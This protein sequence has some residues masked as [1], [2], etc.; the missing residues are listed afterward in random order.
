MSKET[1]HLAL[2]CDR[3]VADG[4]VAVIGSSRHSLR[5]D[6]KLSVHVI[7]FGLGDDIRDRVSHMISTR[8]RDTAIE[9]IAVSTDRLK[10]FPK[11]ASLSHVTLV[12]YARLL[13][14]ELLPGVDR[15]IYL[16]CD[17]LV[18]GDLAEIAH[19]RLGDAALAAAIDTVIPCVGHERESLIKDLA[20]LRPDLPY[21]NAGVLVLDLAKLRALDATRLYAEALKKVEARY[22]D[23]SVLN[24]VFHGHWKQLPARWNRQILLGGAFTVF[25]DRSHGIWHFSSKLKPWHFRRRGVRGLVAQWFAENESIG[26]TPTST[27]TTLAHASAIKD[28][29]KWMRSWIARRGN[30]RAIDRE[31]F[32]SYE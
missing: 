1:I 32:A 15:A 30:D 8:L 16:D 13:L 12:T 29:F 7:D 26:W 4:L 14:H 18:T 28:L 19:A 3:N 10:H 5:S 31:Q 24:A 23:Q 9:F 25:P 22:A 6:C 27:P 17:L 11:P 2:C 21:F 20:G